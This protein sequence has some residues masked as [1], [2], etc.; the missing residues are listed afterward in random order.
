MN[1]SKIHTFY[2]LQ[3]FKNPQKSILH[4]TTAFYMIAAKGGERK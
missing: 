4:D 3:N 2:P 1:N